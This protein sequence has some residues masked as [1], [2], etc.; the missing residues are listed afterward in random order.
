MLEVLIIVGIVIAAGVLL[1]LWLDM[2]DI[3]IDLIASLAQLV[4]AVVALFASFL[5][6]LANALRRWLKKPHNSMLP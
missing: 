2:A 4:A 3:A 6:L 1:L 5:V